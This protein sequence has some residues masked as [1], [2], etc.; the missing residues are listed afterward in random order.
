MINSQFISNTALE[1]GATF[2]WNNPFYLKEILYANNL[3]KN[4]INKDT[5][6]PDSLAIMIPK[7]Y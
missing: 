2:V 7:S 4:L 5:Y 6:E 1:K 3:C